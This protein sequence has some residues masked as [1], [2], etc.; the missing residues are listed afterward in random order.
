M[1]VMKRYAQTRKE[2][3]CMLQFAIWQGRWRYKLIIGQEMLKLIVYVCES[4]LTLKKDYHL[5]QKKNVIIMQ[6][7]TYIH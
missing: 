1:F 2:M 3:I 6:T 5:S 4:L 7:F